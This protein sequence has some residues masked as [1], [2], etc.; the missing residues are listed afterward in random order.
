[1]PDINFINKSL[2]NTIQIDFPIDSR[3]FHVIAQKLGLTEEEVINRIKQMKDDLLI[4]RIGGNFSPDKLGYYSTLCTAKVPEEKI[5][6]F[7]KT[8]NSYS[9]VTHNYQRNH[10]FNIWFT[11][12]A[13]SVAMIEKSLKDISEMTQVAPILNLPATKVFKISANFK[14]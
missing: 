13:S 2:L 4:R 12:I 8:V 9:G 11:F 6:L 7:T 1:M 3:P 14:V 5:G 10:E